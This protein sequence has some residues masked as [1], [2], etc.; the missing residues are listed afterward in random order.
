IVEIPAG[1]P[2]GR[3][4]CG[5][6]SDQIARSA[7]RPIGNAGLFSTASDLARFAAAFL[8]SDEVFPLEAIRLMRTKG[9]ADAGHPRS[10][11]WDL[12]PGL[13]PV[14]FS[15]ETFFHTGWTGQSFYIDPAKDRFAIILSNRHGDHEGSKRWRRDVAAELCRRESA[16]VHDSTR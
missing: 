5:V 6:I 8:R 10:F 2:V 12:D 3:P 14:G 1:F 4:G 13:I 7:E 11:G 15:P 16:H 9:H